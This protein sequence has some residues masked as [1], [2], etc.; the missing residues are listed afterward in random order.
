VCGHDPA[1]PCFRCTLAPLGTR[2]NMSTET[3]DNLG[4]KFPSAEIFFC[5]YECSSVCIIF[6]RQVKS[7]ILKDINLA[8]SK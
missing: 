5:L 1:I 2:E 4:G 7:L 3:V 6:R 8:P